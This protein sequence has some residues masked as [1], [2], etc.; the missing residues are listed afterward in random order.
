MSEGKEFYTVDELRNRLSISTKVFWGHQ[1]I[2]ERSLEEIARHGIKRIELL[3]SCEQFDMT[4]IRS[5]KVIGK[6]C[7]SCGIKIVAYHASQ[8]C[9]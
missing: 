6:A 3:E 5:M 2:S 7:E 1:P 8:T 9:F 4:D